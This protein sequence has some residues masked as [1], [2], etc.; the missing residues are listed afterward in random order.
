[1]TADEQPTTGAGPWIAGL[2]LLCL[3]CPCVGLGVFAVGYDDSGP[4]YFV[5]DQ[6]GVVYYT[7]GE[8]VASTVNSR[9]LLPSD[10][11]MLRTAVEEIAVLWPGEG[12]PYLRYPDSVCAVTT[13]CR[14]V[15]DA[16]PSGPLRTSPSVGNPAYPG[17]SIA[18]PREIVLGFRVEGCIHLTAWLAGARHSPTTGSHGGRLTFASGEFLD[19]P[20]AFARELAAALGREELSVVELVGG[21]RGGR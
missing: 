1:M 5:T 12:G 9:P 14:A 3:A 10:L 19:L 13:Q 16:I 8:I 15:V 6:A 21:S 18:K 7:S 2:A 17:W 11:P 4:K 20:P